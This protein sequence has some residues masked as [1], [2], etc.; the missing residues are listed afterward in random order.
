MLGDLKFSFMLL[1]V[2]GVF[3]GYRFTPLSGASTGPVVSA[4]DALPVLPSGEAVLPDEAASLTTIL[5]DGYVEVKES[6]VSLDSDEIKSPLETPTTSDLPVIASSEPLIPVEEVSRSTPAEP[7]SLKGASAAAELDNPTEGHESAPDAPTSQEGVTGHHDA[8]S[9]TSPAVTEFVPF[10]ESD[11]S[12]PK[13]R[14]APGKG[15]ANAPTTPVSAEVAEPKR[16][17]ASPG[18][19]RTSLLGAAASAPAAGK[20]IPAHP[21]FKRYLDQKA[22]FVRA[23]DSLDSIAERLYQDKSMAQSLLDRNR[24]QLRRAEDL[25]PG[26]TL[27]L[28]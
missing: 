10:V 16:A 8:G 22:Y 25:Q 19:A 5:P 9:E 4:N 6:R 12:A 21:Y 11:D 20:S 24:S 15:A 26:M 27:R 7:R 3:V 2:W 13:V 28:P 17:V 14:Q 18:E 1:A 23:G